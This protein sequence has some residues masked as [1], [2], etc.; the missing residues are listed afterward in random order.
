MTRKEIL[1]NLKGVIPPVVTPFDRRGKIEEGLFRENLQKLAGIGLSGILV[2]GSTGE[3]PYLADSERLRLI[4][5]AREVVRPPEILIAGTGLES[6]E[7]TVRLSR[8]AVQRGA[9]AVLVLT[10][11]Y[12]KSRMD[13]DALVAHYRC[14]AEKVNRPVAVY[15]IPQ[16][17][18]LHVEPATVGRLSRLPNVAGLKDSSGDFAFLRAVLR[19]V[20]SG[21]PVLVGAASIFYRA[22]RAGAT[23]AVLDQ[24]DYA[25]ELSLGLYQAFLQGRRKAALEFQER[26]SLLSR[27]VSMPFGVPGAKAALDLSG[28]GGGFPR[29][30]L[31]PL[32]PAARKSVAAAL[33]EARAGL[34]Y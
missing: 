5:L 10:P 21:F 7:A 28:Y 17:T 24:A 26:L 31:A 33:R 9:D 34:E 14:V 18:G 11:N 16:F 15:L 6:T 22:L 3:A 4:E 30:P 8:E 19:R 29:P 12:Y 25:P 1:Q 23:G 27:T 32:G 2:A 20:R 13:A